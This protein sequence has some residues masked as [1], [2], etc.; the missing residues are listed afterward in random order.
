M[1]IK[2]KVMCLSVCV[3]VLVCLVVRFVHK[4]HLIQQ[5]SSTTFNLLSM[6]F[7]KGDIHIIVVAGFD[8]EGCTYL[9]L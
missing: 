3:C 1:Q 5:Q 7:K 2:N 9:C 6:S 4:G 8:F